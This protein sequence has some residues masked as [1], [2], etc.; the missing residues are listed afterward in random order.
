MGY[1]RHAL[2][3]AIKSLL[4]EGLIWRKQGKGTFAGQ[5]LDK[6]QLLLAE[7]VGEPNFVKAIKARLCT[8]PTL[9]AM[10]VRQ[11]LPADIERKRNIALRTLEATDP[12][13]MELR[14]GALHRL[15]AWTAV[16]KP[17]LKALSMIDEI[18]SNDDWRGLRAAG[19]GAVAGHAADQQS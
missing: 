7:I 16:N 9:A 17:L 11:A 4:V 15:I 19:K 14:D 12:D 1:G 10:A 2:R 18:R 3:G 13:S 6:T 8:E 5:P